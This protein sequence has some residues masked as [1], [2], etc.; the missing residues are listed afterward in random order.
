MSVQVL[1]GGDGDDIFAYSLNGRGQDTIKDFEIEGGTIRFY[2]EQRSLDAL[3]LS[4]VWA[5]IGSDVNLVNASNEILLILQNTNL[6]AL[7]TQ[8]ADNGELSVF[9]FV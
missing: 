9:E 4:L 8:M 3:N 7:N 1:T 6:I 5:Q 2:T